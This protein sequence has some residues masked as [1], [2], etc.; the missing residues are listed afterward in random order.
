VEIA[1]LIQEIINIASLDI[2]YNTFIEFLAKQNT[3][4]KSLGGVY[5]KTTYSKRQLFISTSEGSPYRQS[6]RFD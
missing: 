5:K 6:L 3:T 4:R 1:R 2:W